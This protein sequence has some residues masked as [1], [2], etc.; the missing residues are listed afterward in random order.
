MGPADH[1]V[2]KMPLSRQMTFTLRHRHINLSE[3][4]LWGVG[5]AVADQV[6]QSRGAVLHGRADLAF[7]RYLNAVSR[8]KLHPSQVI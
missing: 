8:P 5:Q 2:D 4:Q 1:S 7:V 6:A 3:A